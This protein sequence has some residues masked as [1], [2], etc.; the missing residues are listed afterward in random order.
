[1]AIQSIRTGVAMSQKEEPIYVS[2]CRVNKL[3]E[4][5]WK[6]ERNVCHYLPQLSFGGRVYPYT[7]TWVW[8]TLGK[9]V[10][11]ARV[12]QVAFKLY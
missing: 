3:H 11:S 5:L 10:F 1:M 8:V 6:V 12:Y 2:K 4:E 7:Q 9:C